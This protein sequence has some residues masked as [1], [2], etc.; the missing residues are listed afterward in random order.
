MLAELLGTLLV[1]G[2]IAR[3]KSQQLNIC[4]LNFIYTTI[5][6]WL[7]WAHSK[8]TDTN[9][10]RWRKQLRASESL[11]QPKLRFSVQTTDL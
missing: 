11:S 1:A 7:Y 6:C 3:T 9:F 5:T 10:Y 4:F 2:V 8:V